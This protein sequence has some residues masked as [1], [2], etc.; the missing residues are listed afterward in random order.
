MIVYMEIC[1]IMYSCRNLCYLWRSNQKG[2][3]RNI[4]GM[5]YSWDYLEKL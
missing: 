4:L 1:G 5:P 2:G 3:G